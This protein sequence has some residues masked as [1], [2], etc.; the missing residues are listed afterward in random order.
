MH[1][2]DADSI[3]QAVTEDKR[4]LFQLPWKRVAL[5]HPQL[6]LQLMR[7]ALETADSDVALVK[8]WNLV[9]W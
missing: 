5:R 7:M 4:L 8:R 6:G 1:L 3:D 9:R 2:K